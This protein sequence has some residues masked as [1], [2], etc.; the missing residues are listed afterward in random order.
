L[1]QQLGVPA[2]VRGVV[3]AEVG[4]DTAGGKLRPGDV[5]EAI[6]QEPIASVQDYQQAIQSLDPEQPQ[7]L[8]VCRHR[9]RSFVV[10]KPG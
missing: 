3:I 9:S 2:N 4:S 10:V 7:V 1:A 5:I 8:S 6:N